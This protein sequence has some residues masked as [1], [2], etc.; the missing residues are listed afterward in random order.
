MRAA[1]R[2]VAKRAQ[3]AC[4]YAEGFRRV[5]FGGIESMARDQHIPEDV[6]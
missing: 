1:G 2:A 5:R 4:T 6:Q 3:L